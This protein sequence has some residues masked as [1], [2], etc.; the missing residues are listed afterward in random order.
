MREIIHGRH[1]R[2]KAGFTIIELLVVIAIILILA[3]ILLPNLSQ[4]RLM[5]LKV[6]CASN[7]HQLGIAYALY[8]EDTRRY[9]GIGW[10]GGATNKPHDF[11]RFNGTLGQ[12]GCAPRTS[13]NTSKVCALG[14]FAN[15]SDRPCEKTVFICPAE[16]SNTL[17]SYRSMIELCDPNCG[18][19]PFMASTIKYASST[20]LLWEVDGT[21]SNEAD[22]GDRC[23]WGPDRDLVKKQHMGGTNVLFC[24]GHVGWALKGPDG[25]GVDTFGIKNDMVNGRGCTPANFTNP[26]FVK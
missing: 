3:R 20:F 18:A 9:P 22:G 6:Q 11:A 21:N 17:I 4:A 14:I 10:S 13:P 12:E 16:T 1:V 24:D 7:L 8:I 23:A 15:P 5:A 2:A 19:G 26:L 25:N